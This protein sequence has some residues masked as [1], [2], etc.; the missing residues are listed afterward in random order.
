MFRQ[1]SLAKSESQS[2]AQ[3]DHRATVVPTCDVYENNDEILVVVDLP[4]VAKEAVKVHLDKGV[5]S[6]EARRELQPREGTSLGAEYRDCDFRRQFAIPGG[7]DPAK[8]NAELK[9]GVLHLR[10]PKSE[11]LKPRQIAVRAE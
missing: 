2:V 11:A 3:A 10:L 8:I 5:L 9:S 7:I 6:L 1:S 4:G